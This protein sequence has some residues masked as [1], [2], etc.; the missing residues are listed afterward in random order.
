MIINRDEKETVLK[1]EDP[2]SLA[3]FECV[4]GISDGGNG[5]SEFRLKVFDG[6]AE[7][8][9]KMFGVW[10]RSRFL[11]FLKQVVYEM[12]LLEKNGN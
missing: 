8:E 5:G 10:E 3:N 9:I 11:P 4:I 12:E 6:Q 7:G 2:A 1:D